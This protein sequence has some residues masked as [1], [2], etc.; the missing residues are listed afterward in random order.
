V[1]LVQQDPVREAGAL[2]QQVQGWQERAN[3]LDFLL[4]RPT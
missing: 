1:R 3:V 4:V 2:A